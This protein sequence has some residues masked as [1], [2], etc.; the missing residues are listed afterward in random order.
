VL[1]SSQQLFQDALHALEVGELR[2]D[3]GESVGSDLPDGSAI[4]SVLEQQQLSDFLQREAELL[5]PFDEADALDKARRV[6]PK[7]PCA[8]WHRKELSV[9]VVADGLDTD[10]GR[11]G[12]PSN[13]Q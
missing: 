6:L 2:V 7:C 10:V 9:L 1:A 8:R 5:S 12:K 11:T 13:R 4:G 3:L